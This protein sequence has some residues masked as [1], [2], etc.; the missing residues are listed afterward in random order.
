MIRT[1]NTPKQTIPLPAFCLA[2]AGSLCLSG[3]FLLYFKLPLFLT[4]PLAVGLLLLL[5]W[6]FRLSFSRRTAVFSATFSVLLAASFII[7]G[8][9]NT[10]TGYFASFYGLDILYG[11]VLTAVFFLCSLRLMEFTRHHSVRLTA[12][13][14]FSPRRVWGGSSF[15]FVLCWLPCLAVFYP[16]GVSIDSLSVLLYATGQAPITNHHPVLYTLLTKAF[17]G[18]SHLLGH[19]TNFG[20]ALFLFVQ[21]AACAAVAGYMMSWL[22]KKGYSLRVMVPVLCYF[23][24]NPIIAMYASTMWKDILFRDRKSVV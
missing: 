20:I 17:L 15:F 23:A 9:I 14:Q 1:I 21:I 12:Y 2:V 7:G 6:T 11:T 18:I 8:K 19:G 22:C 5:L 24:L 4:A 10:R 13:C 3:L 16:G